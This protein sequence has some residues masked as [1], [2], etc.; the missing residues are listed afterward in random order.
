M[1]VD[2]WP[3]SS[4]ALKTSSWEGQARERVCVCVPAKWCVRGGEGGVPCLSW[5][6]PLWT[7]AQRSMRR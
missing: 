7:L 6:H 5:T 3:S 4:S 2:E 1:A